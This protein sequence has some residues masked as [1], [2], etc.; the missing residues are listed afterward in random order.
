MTLLLYRLGRAAVRRRRAVVAA[1]VVIAVAAVVL[2]QVAGG[3]TSDRFEVPDVEAQTALDVLDDEFPTAAGTSAQLV[4]AAEGGALTDAAPAAAVD[5]ALADVASQPDVG[6]VGELQLAPGGEVGVADVQ[7]DVP[8][9]DIRD[10]AFARLEAT[11]EAAAATGDVRME[12]GGDLPSEAVQPEV[13]GQEGIGFLVAM[14][15]LLVAFGS[16]IAMG[17]PV[18]LA[19]LGLVTTSGLTALAAAVIDINST[20]P[21]L[22]TMIGVGVGIDYALFIVTRHREHMAAGMTVEESASRAIATSGAAVLFAGTTVVIAILGLAIAGIPAVT[23]MGAVSAASV[24]IMVALALTLLPALLGFAGHRIDAVRLPRPWRR[25]SGAAGAAGVH[26]PGGRET[27]WHRWGREVSAHPWRWLTLGVVVLG[28]L[29]APVAGLRLGMTDNGTASEDLTT[30]RAYDL[31]ADGFGAGVNG[32]LLLSV[33]LPEGTTV[34]DLAPLSDAL[35]ADSGVAEVA[36]ARPNE[37]GTAAVMRV[38]PTTS[39]QDE[40]TVDTVHRLRDDVIPEAVAGTGAEVHVGGQAAMWIDMSERVESRLPWFVGAVL[41]LSVLLLMVV[42]RSVAVPL[43]A[44]AMNLLSIGASYGLIVAV[45]QWGWGNELFGVDQTL[46][47]VSFVPMMLFAVL[48]GLSMDYEVFLLS[49][50]REEYLHRGDNDSAVVEGI[51]STARVITS[52]ALIMISVFAA[53]VLSVDPVVKMFGL[54]LATAVFVDATVVRIVLVPATMRLLGDRNWWLPGWLDRLLPNL[55]V[56]GGVG[57]PAPAYEADPDP[58]AGGDDEPDPEGR[59]LE[60]ALA[61]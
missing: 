28:L 11:A 22:A 36:P 9:D 44:A 46:P 17:L 56:E 42:F 27:V 13:G 43:K 59:P 24:A 18:G 3:E 51:A 41:L 40:A 20:A 52:A 57:L 39:P 34:D 4:F 50:V 5:A 21:I 45:F 1:W 8:S 31:I 12:L 16:V 35:A 25:R 14:V 38:V 23:V 49:R 19:L 61:G 2:G 33:E 10:E 32:P 6:A 54:G 15:V 55:D 60:P 53:F 7:Y 37:A 58:A 29:T 26:V 30:R 48:F 47:I